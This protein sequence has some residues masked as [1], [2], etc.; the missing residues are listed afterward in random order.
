[1]DGGVDPVTARSCIAAGAT[2]LVAGAAV[3]KDGPARYAA[4]IAAIR[5]R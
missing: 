2:A 1:V 3:F 5:G 4:N